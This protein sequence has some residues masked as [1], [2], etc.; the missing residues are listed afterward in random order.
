[1]L[2]CFIDDYLIYCKSL[3]L[4]QNAIK[5]LSRYIKHLDDFLQKN[6]LEN[7]THVQYKHLVA[8]TVS[9]QAG[10]TTLKA[11]IWSLKKFFCWLLLNGLIKDNPAKDL[12]PPKIPKKEARFLSKDE[13]KVIF[14]ALSESSHTPTGLRNFLI[15]SLMAVCG[16]RKSS[17]VALDKEDYDAAEQTLKL[18]EKGLAGKRTLPIPSAVCLLLN[19]F[20]KDAN[21]L[22]GPLFTNRRKQRLKPD[23]VNKILGKLK[24]NL[25][26]QGH[27]FAKTLHPHIFRH[28]AASQLNEVANFTLSKEMLGHRNAQNTRKYIHLSYNSYGVYMKQHPYFN[29]EF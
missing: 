15:I 28:S 11:R 23:G 12:S 7:I 1:M 2:K 8:F 27:S 10:P 14:I 20:I 29:R 16:L 19:E 6:G 26:L 13:L 3:A 24:E 9:N 5:E 22:A 21:L 4:S 18:R 17:V 25:L